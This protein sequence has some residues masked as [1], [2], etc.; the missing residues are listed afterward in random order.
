MKITK[1]QLRRII[2]EEKR[3]LL[4]EVDTINAKNELEL[5]MDEYIKARVMDGET[6][7]SRLH[8]EIVGIA[9]SLLADA[10]LGDGNIDTSRYVTLRDPDYD[11]DADA[12][13]GDLLKDYR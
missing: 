7:S 3:K 12:T 4:S 9:D 10:E 8:R 13:A 2:K 5:V 11:Y 6:D 1:R